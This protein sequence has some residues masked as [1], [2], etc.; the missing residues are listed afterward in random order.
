MKLFNTIDQDLL[1][2]RRRRYSYCGLG[3]ACKNGGSQVRAYCQGVACSSRR[4][5]S[6]VRPEVR[7][8]EKKKEKER[9]KDHPLPHPLALFLVASLC[10]VFD[11]FAPRV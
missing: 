3:G 10:A 7:E 9:E 11:C 8:Q 4:L 2:Y 1:T 6:G 5:D